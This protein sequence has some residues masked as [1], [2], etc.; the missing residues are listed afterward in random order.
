MPKYLVHLVWFLCFV[1]SC[2][3]TDDDDSG[4]DDTGIPAD[5]DAGDD[6]TAIPDDDSGDDDTEP[7]ALR[8]ACDLEDKVGWFVVQHEVEYTVVS[9]E[10]RD[11]VVPSAVLE[12]VLEQGG[13]RLLRSNNPFCDPPCAWDETCDFDGD[14]IPYPTNLDVGTVTITGLNKEVSMEPPGGGLPASYFD[15]EMPHPGFEPGAAIQLDASGNDTAG[16][17]LYGEGLAPLVASDDAWIVREDEPLEVLWTPSL[18]E[19]VH[20]LLRLNIDQHG[21]TPVE[22]WCEV[23]DSGATSVPADVMNALLGY[24]VSGFASGNIYRRSVDSIQIDAGCVEFQVYSHLAAELQVDGHIP[25]DSPDDCPDGMVCD[26]PTG[27][28]VPE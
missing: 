17:T 5:D 24:G 12:N 2:N 25:C 1:L 14:C 28:C 16:F 3:G 22:V 20:I 4:D 23:E 18:G 21:T 8:G 10:V 13:C 19:Q 26:I 9:G 15:T 11:S 7:P 27:T 6:D